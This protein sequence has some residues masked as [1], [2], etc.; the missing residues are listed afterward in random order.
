MIT[1]TVQVQFAWWW[2]PYMA[3]MLTLAKL[4]VGVDLDRFG[5]TAKRAM[6]VTLQTETC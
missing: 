2:R 3:A 5:A 4:G 1:G 6:T